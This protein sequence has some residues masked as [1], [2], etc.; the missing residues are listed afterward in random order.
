MKIL[1]LSVLCN[2]LNVAARQ[3][4]V[5]TWIFSP[6]PHRHREKDYTYKLR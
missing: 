3:V 2:R 4:E 1:E 5:G 6:N